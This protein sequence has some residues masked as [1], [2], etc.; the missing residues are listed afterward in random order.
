MARFGT[1]HQNWGWCSDQ[2]GKL[3]NS[4]A[5]PLKVTASHIKVKWQLQ[6]FLLPVR[7]PSNFPIARRLWIVYSWFLHATIQPLFSCLCFLSHIC[8][9]FVFLYICSVMDSLPWLIPKLSNFCCCLSVQIYIVTYHYNCKGG[10][11]ESHQSW[12]LPA[13]LSNYQ[14]PWNKLAEKGTRSFFS[15]NLTFN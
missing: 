8:C 1:S 5:R 3:D 6:I 15:W 9:I 4:T 11:V 13:S 2:C 10:R 7:I 12:R 14:R